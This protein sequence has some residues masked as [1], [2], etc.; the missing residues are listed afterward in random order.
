MLL[1]LI[2]ITVQ[3][4]VPVGTVITDCGFGVSA[5]LT[6]PTCPGNPDGSIQLVFTDASQNIAVDW[7]NVNVADSPT[8]ENLSAGTYLVALSNAD[9]ADTLSYTLVN[10]PIV[11]PDLFLT[12]CTNTAEVNLLD[13]VTGG[14][15]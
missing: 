14:T 3:A 7:L 11:A 13:G 9:C 5:S 10:N 12:F 4:Q 6:N 8:L 15:G 2:T 1:T